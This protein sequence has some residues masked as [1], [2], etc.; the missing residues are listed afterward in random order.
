[1]LEGLSPKSD[2]HVFAWTF[3]LEV[4]KEEKVSSREAAKQEKKAAREAAKQEKKEEKLA[5]REAA[6]Q[7]KKAARE[8]AKQE[9]K[10]LRKA[11]KKEK[12]LELVSLEL[13]Q[14]KETIV[15]LQMDGKFEDAD[16]NILK[17]EQKLKLTDTE[18]NLKEKLLI[19]AEEKCNFS[20]NFVFFIK[21]A[22]RPYK[23]ALGPC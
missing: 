9:K 21:T 1:M 10:A 6:K 19:E 5:A 17:L 20:E 22:L 12:D 7:E 23:S 13:K 8:A 2:S 14:A 16:L 11:Q 18:L 4:I 15:K 3:S